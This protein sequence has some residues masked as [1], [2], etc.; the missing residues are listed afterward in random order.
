M[1]QRI[2]VE[3]YNQSFI[4]NSEDDERYVQEI[5][6]YV[7]EKMRQMGE[8]T[9]NTMPMRMAIMAALSI[10]D[11]YHKALQREAATQKEIERLSSL[12]LERIAQSEAPEGRTP[13]DSSPN[14]FSTVG[15]VTSA[16]N[17]AKKEVSRLS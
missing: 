14:T 9:K 6:S 16:E 10:A 4:V 11:E 12:I 1:K 7:D 15:S 8:N 2:E 13:A 17:N 5:A 3:I